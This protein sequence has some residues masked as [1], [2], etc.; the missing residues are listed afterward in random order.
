MLHLLL[1]QISGEYFVGYA[2]EEACAA[3]MPLDLVPAEIVGALLLGLLLKLSD[4]RFLQGARALTTGGEES[5]RGLLL[6]DAW[7]ALPC[8]DKV[9]ASKWK[10]HIGEL[11]VFTVVVAC[12]LAQITFTSGYFAVAKGVSG[13][14]R[15]IFNGA[16]L[17]KLFRRPPP[18]CL[19]PTDELLVL[20]DDIARSAG[21]LCFV[22]SDLRHFFHTVPVSDYV[23]AFFGL[24]FNRDEAVRFRVLP[25]GWSY[26]PRY[27]QAITWSLL[28]YAE[29][30]EDRL[31]AVYDA[32]AEN[33]PRFVPI[34]VDGTTIGILSVLYDNVLI[35]VAD[36]QMAERWK[37]R[38]E[39]NCSKFHATLKVCDLYLHTNRRAADFNAATHLGLSLGCQRDGGARSG[40]CLTWRH[41]DD[42]RARWG[43]RL[44][45]AK[46]SRLGCRAAA[47]VIGVV[48]WDCTVRLERLRNVAV[49]IDVLRRAAKA[50]GGHKR[51]WLT[52]SVDLTDSENAFLAFRLQRALDNPWLTRAAP[53]TGP[54]AFG[55]S[56]ASDEGLGGVS[57][58]DHGEIGEE[59]FA[60]RLDASDVGTLPENCIFVRELLALE[61]T[62]KRLLLLNKCAADIYVAVDNTAA[63]HATRKGYSTSR[64]GDRIIERIYDK[65]DKHVC[66][67]HLVPIRGDM[68]IADEPSH[69]RAPLSEVRR[70]ATWEAISGYREGNGKEYS[71]PSD[72]LEHG[73][74]VQHADDGCGIDAWSH[75]REA[76]ESIAALDS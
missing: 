52:E 39:R 54:V 23:S 61:L 41:A 53:R 9:I 45:D 18:V 38:W 56:D 71:A 69:L 65:V 10:R 42:K 43:D 35:A 3:S 40:W 14:S 30:G 7:R 50:V 75:L 34:C 51:R 33:P 72:A 48:L 36:A 74:E 2:E 22:V 1:R 6:P 4:C 68:N 13:F 76:I 27:A 64:H 24:R 32:E 16:R 70:K 11:L 26:S 55:A 58:D 20:L 28:L 66:R 47:K 19:L 12:R 59:F 29:E 73:N 46:R 67:L 25:M 17:N 31:G 15:S 5:F 57:F 49:A 21:K 37:K 8:R 62:V 60:V 63:V 44:A